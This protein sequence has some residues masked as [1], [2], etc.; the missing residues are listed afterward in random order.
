MGGNGS[1]SSNFATT[2]IV[3]SLRSLVSIAQKEKKQ[4]NKQK[5]TNKDK[6]KINC[7]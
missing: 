3:A 4:N 5:G 7:N 6:E 1:C 2:T